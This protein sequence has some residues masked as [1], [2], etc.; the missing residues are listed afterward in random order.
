MCGSWGCLEGQ[1]VLPCAP[2]SRA[3]PVPYLGPGCGVRLE[4]L[5]LHCLLHNSSSTGHLIDPGTRVS[6]NPQQWAEEW[7]EVKSF[8]KT[9]RDHSASRDEENMPLGWHLLCPHGSLEEKQEK[10]PQPAKWKS[11]LVIQTSPCPSS[12]CKWCILLQV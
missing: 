10:L 7:A 8:A 3:Q 4:G 6:H 12:P 9:H 11:Q 5:K 2:P 1:Q